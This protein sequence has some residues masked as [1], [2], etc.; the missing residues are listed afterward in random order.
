MKKLSQYL[1][2]QINYLYLF[3]MLFAVYGAIRASNFD[4]YRISPKF[5]FTVFL[6]LVIV[7][8]ILAHPFLRQKAVVFLQK[9]SQFFRQHLVGI[10]RWIF[11][12]IVLLQI[13]VLANV[14]SS[15]NWDPS[16]VI[17]GVLD[18]RSMDTYLSI[19]PNN[20]LFFFVIYVYNKIV[21]TF[22]PALNGHWFSFQLLNIF[23]MDLSGFVL[24]KATKNLL[25]RKVAYLTLYFYM[26]LFLLSPWIM[27]PY[28]DEISFLLVSIVLYLY[29]ILNFQ[30]PKAYW[31]LM[32]LIGILTGIIYLF[33]PSAIVYLIAWFLI[34]LLQSWRGKKFL[35]RKL[36]ILGVLLVS[37]ALP[38]VA[39]QQ[40]MRIQ[41]LV[42]IDSRQALPWTHFV[43][44]GITGNGGFNHPD[45]EVDKAIA[46]PTLRKES[47]IHIIKQRLN[48]YK[49]AGYAKFLIQKY[50]NNTDRG[51]FGWGTDGNGQVPKHK[52]HN[53]I[54]SALRDT[55]YQQ[56]RKTNIMRFYMQVIWLVLLTGMALTFK[57]Q[58]KSYLLIGMKLTMIGG[59]I[60][61]LLF[62]GGRSR[63]LI[64]YLPFMLIL[65]SVGISN[66][67]T[68]Y[69]QQ[70][71]KA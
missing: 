37:F 36:V 15:I 8:V 68:N 30:A 46:D 9:G 27:V 62:E 35:I 29:S 25:N 49:I 70:K 53:R 13:F 7:F 24:F 18:I 20:S 31:S 4:L 16:Y 3:F 61:L 44:M 57:V 22:I 6:L 66:W 5:I 33:K 65:S 40:F 39:F 60:Y 50:F 69:R 2:R 42:T 54:Q 55:Y 28:T 10:T 14:T 45:L 38:N 52:A 51:D 59:L 17:H 41:T 56:G 34:N 12:I 11:G 67:W 19:N 23:I 58:G 21:S 48:D 32:V 1:F 43:M 63:Y 47:N 26:F 71:L 64:Q